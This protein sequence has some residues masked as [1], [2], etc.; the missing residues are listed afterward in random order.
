MVVADRQHELVGEERP[1]DLGAEHGVLLHLLP[2]LRVETA[3]LEEHAVGDADLA[4]VMEVG[5][6]LELAEDLLGPAELACEHHRVRGH[7]RG[8]TQCVVVLGVERRAQ[9]LEIAEVH[10]LDLFVET[11]VLDRQRQLRG[12]SLE[13]LG[14]ELGEGVFA[15]AGKMKRA[16]DLAFGQQGDGH[17]GVQ[18]REQ[19]VAGWVGNAV[20]I[21]KHEHAPLAKPVEEA[22]VEA[23]GPGARE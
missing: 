10:L 20:G 15:A 9:R 22:P 18:T 5:G 14:V 1:D 11:G 13:Q 17:G 12:D 16:D 2:L 21:A 19:G 8:V 4:D 7:A 23:L 6:L 3:R